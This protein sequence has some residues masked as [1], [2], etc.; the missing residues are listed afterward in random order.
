MKNLSQ[1]EC[2]Q[3][4]CKYFP[5]IKYFSTEM[6]HAHSSKLEEEC[7]LDNSCPQCGFGKILKNDLNIEQIKNHKTLLLG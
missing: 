7:I 4:H 5:R 3:C 2:G 1:I 6:L